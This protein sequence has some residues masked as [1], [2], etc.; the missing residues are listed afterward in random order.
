VGHT[1]Q[2]MVQTCVNHVLQVSTAQLDLNFLKNV[3]LD[4]IALENQKNQNNVLLGN[5]V[6][7]KSFNLAISV[8][9]AQLENIAKMV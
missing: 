5:M 8:L 4:I 6:T 1:N 9:F 3:H 2:E 7:L